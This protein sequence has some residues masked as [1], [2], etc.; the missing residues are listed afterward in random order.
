[1]D[2]EDAAETR[3]V[4]ELMLENAAGLLKETTAKMNKLIMRKGDRDTFAALSK[5]D[6]KTFDL[7]YAHQARLM[8]EH[9]AEV[10]AAEKLTVK[11]PAQRAKPLPSRKT[12]QN[13]PKLRI[14]AT[15]TDID[16]DDHF[17]EV[18]QYLNAQGHADIYGGVGTWRDLASQM[19]S[20]LTSVNR[21][22][23]DAIPADATWPET[24]EQLKLALV[25]HREHL[26][27][28]R[29][30]SKLS[31]GVMTI[32][33]YTKVFED[34][35][36]AVRPACSHCMICK[37]EWKKDASV[38]LDYVEGL[39]ASG[40][41]GGLRRAV[42]IETG[43]ENASHNFDTLVEHAMKMET[44]MAGSKR[45]DR[46]AQSGPPTKD[47]GGG[48]GKGRS[49]RHTP[50]RETTDP[51]RV[52]GGK[53][54]TRCG[55]DNHTSTKC[56]ANYDSQ[57]QTIKTPKPGQEGQ[58]DKP[59]LRCNICNSPDHA[60]YVC[61]KAKGE[62]KDHGHGGGR[63]GR[64]NDKGRGGKK[65]G[66]LGMRTGTEREEAAS[67]SEERERSPKKKPKARCPHCDGK[68]AAASC[69]NFENFEA[70]APSDS[71]E[72]QGSYDYYS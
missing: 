70:A 23:I 72:E 10:D 30:L 32:K 37:D 9:R 27:K 29:T 16:M 59:Y 67:E 31:Q 49:D 35:V 6:K 22:D 38:I 50:A 69:K 12:P 64:G 42:Q 60:Y 51:Q 65:V 66:R 26:A 3:R 61:P 15:T 20:A 21:Q 58:T 71:E 48:K 39:D 25:R 17:V 46:Q 14:T 43:F 40:T 19:F 53:A 4:A 8:S 56:R 34:L 55:K 11:K 63:G 44:S 41:E 1:M 47:R 7:K 52:A 62:S 36:L 33:Q 5:E 57:G 28:A 54:C 68:H 2:E 24:Q 18:G 13:I 45:V